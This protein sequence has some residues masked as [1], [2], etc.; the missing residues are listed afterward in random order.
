[1]H[2]AATDW[3]SLAGRDDNEDSTQHV[4]Q[5]FE[6]TS[7]ADAVQAELRPPTVCWCHVGNRLTQHRY[8]S[9]MCLLG[10]SSVSRDNTNRSQTLLLHFALRLPLQAT[11][12]GAAVTW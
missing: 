9:N 7:S 2:A 8:S 11:S 6:R 12:A 5:T 4:S 1:M 3:V 10:D